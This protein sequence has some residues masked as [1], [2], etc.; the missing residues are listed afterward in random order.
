MYI[1]LI[2]SQYTTHWTRIHKVDKY[3]HL[4]KLGHKMFWNSLIFS[5]IRVKIITQ[6]L[7]LNYKFDTFIYEN[8]WLFM[9]P[10]NLLKIIRY[11]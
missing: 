5:E 2:S 4:V 9:T 8:I 1:S 10:L 11:R 6:Q 7:T 3:V